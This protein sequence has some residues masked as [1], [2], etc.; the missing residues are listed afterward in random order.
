[1]GAAKIIF[2]GIVAVGVIY[3]LAKMPWRVS[4]F[5]AFVAIMLTIFIIVFR[6]AFIT[7]MRG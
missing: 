3:L 5:L 7:N 1:M 4:V 6:A 2:L